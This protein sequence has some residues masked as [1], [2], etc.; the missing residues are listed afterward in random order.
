MCCQLT[1]KLGLASLDHPEA[2]QRE[3]T[4]GVTQVS[5]AQGLGLAE[6]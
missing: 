5:K 3:L 6:D 4:R 1:E 2:E